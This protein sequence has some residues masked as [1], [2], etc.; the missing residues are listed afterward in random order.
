MKSSPSSADCL[1]VVSDRIGGIFNRTG[2]TRAV[3]LH[4]FKAFH[5]IG[6]VGLLH[7][8][9]S[10]GISVQILDLIL[11]FLSNRQLQLVLD[12][13]SSQEYPFTVRAFQ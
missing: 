12:G 13:K 4:T 3:V 7:K 9:K 6:N 11:S 2:A 10:Y 8:P 5:R 1:T